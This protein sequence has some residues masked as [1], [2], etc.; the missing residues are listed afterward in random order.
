MGPLEEI[1]RV[2]AQ[3]AN[4]MKP[5]TVSLPG[6]QFPGKGYIIREPLG[7]VLIISP[8]NYPLNLCLMPL[9]GAIAG[10]ILP[11]CVDVAVVSVSWTNQHQG[12]CVVLKPSEVAGETASAINRLIPKYLEFDTFACVTGNPAAVFLLLSI[13]L[14]CA[15]GGGRWGGGND[16]AAEAGV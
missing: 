5:T 14:I 10:G 9:I 3:L 6:Q 4:W 2:E 13:L 15:G 7:V 11:A 1:E 12:N 16:I 8:W